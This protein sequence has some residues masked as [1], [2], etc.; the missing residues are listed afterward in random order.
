MGYTTE[1]E[2]ACIIKP[3]LPKSFVNEIN[4]L[5]AGRHDGFG[6]GINNGLNHDS[7]NQGT[8]EVPNN[9]VWCHW[10]LENL[11]IDATQIFWDR[12][13]KFYFYEEWMRNILAYIKKHYPSSVIS[14][15]MLYRGEDMRDIGTLTFS[16]LGPALGGVRQTSFV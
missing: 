2:G 6:D 10:E 5:L 16:N 15:E 12:G 7:I 14:G 1:F 13:E 3:Q 9:A 11:T 4:E 8:I